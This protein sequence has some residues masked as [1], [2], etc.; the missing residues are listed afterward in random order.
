MSSMCNG[1]AVRPGEKPAIK[2]TR[3]RAQAQGCE[4]GCGSDAQGEAQPDTLLQTSAFV[5][6]AK[7]SHKAP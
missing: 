7:R 3:A 6:G 4:T 5:S 1:T 2:P